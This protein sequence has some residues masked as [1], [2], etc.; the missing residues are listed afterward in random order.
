MLI[1]L[2]ELLIGTDRAD[3]P[4]GGSRFNIFRRRDDLSP[5][6]LKE[7]SKSKH[8]ICRPS[9]KELLR[10]AVSLHL[11]TLRQCKQAN[12]NEKGQTGF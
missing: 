3:S 6:I 5:A 7:N 10:E 12:V 4:K 2:P 11:Q 1:E 8:L 9:A